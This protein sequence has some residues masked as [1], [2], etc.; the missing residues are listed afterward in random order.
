MILICNSIII[1]DAGPDKNFLYTIYIT[2]RS[3]YI[4]IFRM[5]YLHCTAGPGP[6]AIFLFTDSFRQLFFAGGIV[7]IGRW[8]AD[9][10]NVSLKVI[11]LCQLFR[12]TDD[13][14]FGSASDLTP[15]MQCDGTKAASAKASSVSSY[16]ES[17]FFDRRN[18]ALFFIHRMICPFKIH[19]IQIIQLIS[20]KRWLRRI[21]NYINIIIVFFCQCTSI[22]MITVFMLHHK[23]V[24]ISL[25]TALY[26][27]IIGQHDKIRI[28]WQFF[29]DI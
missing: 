10:V 13:R 9:I 19:I 15:L 27:F 21:L 2:N 1:S 28:I 7:E 5:I 20:F 12:F 14:L 16:A 11:Q 22:D 24:A 17:H 18:T 23:T 29:T 8:S 25:F 6:Q 3:E 4:Q 26:F